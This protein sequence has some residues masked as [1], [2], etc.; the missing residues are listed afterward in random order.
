MEFLMEQFVVS[1]LN[2]PEVLKLS[3]SNEVRE[4]LRRA[5]MEQASDICRPEFT[6]GGP[7][8]DGDL[9]SDADDLVSAIVDLGCRVPPKGWLCTRQVGH[10][11]PC[12]AIPVT[13]TD[14][15]EQT[16]G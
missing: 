10:Q 2:R 1:S 5:F 11:G 3:L 4:T 6:I 16:N 12:A 13:V 14:P 9:A 8:V 7:S 15:A